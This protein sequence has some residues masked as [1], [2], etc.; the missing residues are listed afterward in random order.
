MIYTTKELAEILKVHHL[1]IIKWINEGKI[2]ATKLGRI[3]R[4]RKEDF[5][6]FIKKGKQ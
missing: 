1:T 2:K 3:W 5:D 6:E 4:V